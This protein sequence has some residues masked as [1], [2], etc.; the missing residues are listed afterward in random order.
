M[1]FR[2]TAK[3]GLTL[4]E[5][6]I[7]MAI[8]GVLAAMLLPKFE[9]LTN[10]ANEAAAASSAVDAAKLI[11]QYKAVK[12]VYP[13]RW[14][15][16]TDG[17]ALWTAGSVATTTK[18]LNSEL[19][20]SG[21]T[22]DKIIQG[23]LSST[24]VA[25][26]QKAGIVNVLNLNTASVSSS[27]R[28]G[29]LFTVVA[30]ISTSTPIAIVNSASTGGKK[31]IDHIYRGNLLTGTTTASQG[32]SGTINPSSTGAAD[33][34]T[35]LVVF[36]LGPQNALIP[37]SMLEA[38]TYGNAEAQYIYNRLLV[39]FEVTASKAT[40]KAILGADGD[41]LDDMSE[42]LQNGATL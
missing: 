5:L 18:G 30:P 24:Q 14:D 4:I 39:V 16:L 1:K 20:G 13:D 8:L 42:R 38:P 26:L 27:L 34:N 21:S 40:F 32:V 6:V 41:T 25:A 15:S 17:S 22:T 33:P 2:T 11:G 12:T 23:T 29:D 3:R 28:P 9:G 37:N 36:G 31:I 35:Q 7:V 19:T 10:A